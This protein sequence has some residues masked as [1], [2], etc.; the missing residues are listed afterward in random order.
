[1]PPRSATSPCPAPPPPKIHI[2]TLLR[3]ARSSSTALHLSRLWRWRRPSARFRGSRSIISRI[4]SRR[5][6]SGA[7][8]WINSCSDLSDEYIWSSL[9][10]KHL[11]LPR[12]RSDSQSVV[13]Q[14][15]S[16]SEFGFWNLGYQPTNAFV[17]FVIISR[18]ALRFDPIRVI[19]GFLHTCILHSSSSSS[20][21]V[22]VMSP[23]YEWFGDFTSFLFCWS[24]CFFTFTFTFIFISCPHVMS[25]CHL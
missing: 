21:S 16:Q 24:E 2:R 5:R 11:S 8:L 19:E 9:A 12:G 14:S 20:S 18:P 25:S 3:T 10:C 23:Y 15:V 17:L 22:L 4:S 6:F 1:M 13:I 7:I